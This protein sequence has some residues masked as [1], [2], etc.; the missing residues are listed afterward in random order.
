ML[1]G[2]CNKNREKDEKE[3][4][5]DDDQEKDYIKCAIKIQGIKMGLI[6]Y[7]FQT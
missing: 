1:F 6:S 2:R 7:H 3:A 5:D 4:R